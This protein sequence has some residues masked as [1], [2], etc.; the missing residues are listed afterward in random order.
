[1]F[2]KQITNQALR[3]VLLALV[4]LTFSVGAWAQNITVTGTVTDKS[5][6]P[7]IGVYVL[8]Q[9][10]QNGTSTDIDGK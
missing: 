7:I 9:G 3:F 8:V 4:S 6:E 10:T 2:I 5:G 1:M